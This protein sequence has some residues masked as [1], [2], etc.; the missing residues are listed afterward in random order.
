MTLQEFSNNMMTMKRKFAWVKFQMVLLGI[1]S[2]SVLV[3]LL[4]VLSS[5]NV[6]LGKDGIALMF[7]VLVCKWILLSG[8]VNNKSNLLKEYDACVVQAEKEG[9]IIRRKDM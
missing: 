6:T 8:L 9:L 4:Y 7:L 2:L 3:L 5:E 1:V